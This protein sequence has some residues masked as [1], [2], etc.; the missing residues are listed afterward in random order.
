MVTNND[1]RFIYI[2]Y[3]EESGCGTKQLREKLM[4][5]EHVAEHATIANGTNINNSSQRSKHGMQGI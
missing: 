5:K 2:G 3:I 1:T 4:W